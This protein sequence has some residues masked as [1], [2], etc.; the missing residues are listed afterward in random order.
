MTPTPITHSATWKALALER[1]AWKQLHLR[2]LFARD[3]KRGERYALLLDAAEETLLLDYSKNLIRPQTLKLLL[4]LAKETGVKTLRDAMFAGE[5]INL[6]EGRA[7]LHTALR[8][9]AASRRPEVSAV[10]ERMRVF[11]DRVRT[12]KWKGYTG[13]PITDVVNIGIGGSDL[14]PAMACIALK[15]YG[16]NIRAHFVS[17]VDPSQLADTLEDLNPATTLFVVAS[18]TFTTQETLLNAQA[19]RAWIIDA[20]KD[21]KAV[22]RHFVAVSTNLDAV[23][24]F[25]IDPANAFGFWDWVG[26]RYS[27]W[28]AI[29]LPIALYIGMDAFEELLAGARDMD[30]HFQTAP[31]DQNMPVLMALLG[32]WYNNFWDA[33]SYA[34]LPYEQRLARFPAY[35]QQL[36]MESNGKGITREGKP[37]ACSTG[38]VLFGEPG[39]NGQHAFY[40]LIHQG[41][42]LIPCDFIA[43][44]ESHNDLNG[45]HAVLLSNF[46]AQ[47]EALMR[48]KSFDEATRELAAEGKKTAE[49]KA[50]A[51]HKVFPGNRPSNSLVYRKLTPR[52]LGRL[53]ALYEHKVFVQGAIWN[54]NSFDQWGVELGKQLAKVI[55]PELTGGKPGMHDS[56]TLHLIRHIKG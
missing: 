14:G 53:I 21:E 11:V 44:R 13:K 46:L 45:Q 49:I 27:L 18:K 47:T 35:L 34:V 23:A 51:P 26:G 37:V 7:V 1:A 54:V 22:A 32:L 5:A 17:N 56:S 33:Q 52:T 48:G 43:G 4:K 38:P 16:G 50:L 10:L 25:G 20:A 19:A 55:L 41:Q 9:D 3:K 30:T 6:T 15:P 40:Q 39:T 12:G 2:D 31:F 28:S 29:G 24:A 8:A 36:D 42:K